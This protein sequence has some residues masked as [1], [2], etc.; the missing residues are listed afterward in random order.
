MNNC[1]LLEQMKSVRTS[2]KQSCCKRLKVMLRPPKAPAL[3]TLLPYLGPL[4]HRYSAMRR[5]LSRQ[6]NPLGSPCPS[7]HHKCICRPRRLKCWPSL[8]MALI[9]R[10]A[11]LPLHMTEKHCFQ[12]PPIGLAPWAHSQAAFWKGC[13]SHHLPEAER[14]QR[15]LPPLS[16]AESEE[17][18]YWSASQARPDSHA[19]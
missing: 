16:F 18:G 1:L 11:C 7:R 15:L 17:Y 2:L 8:C 14:P 19:M 3:S 6:G 4:R 12:D 9:K 5:L 13:S 10:W